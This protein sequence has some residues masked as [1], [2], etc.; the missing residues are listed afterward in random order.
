[1]PCNVLSWQ[2]GNGESTV[3]AGVAVEIL[4]G[5]PSGEEIWAGK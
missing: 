3:E 4:I 5:G 1:M 2:W